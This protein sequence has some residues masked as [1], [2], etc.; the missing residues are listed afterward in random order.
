[1]SDTKLIAV[2][3]A[4]GTQGGGLVR[5]ILDDPDGGFTARAVTRQPGSEKARGLAELGVEVVPGDA[6]RAGGL[7]VAFDGAYGAYCVTNF[8]EHAS[9]ERELAQATEMARATR[10]AGVTHVVWS[11]LEDTRRTVPL[12]DDRLPTLN[13]RYKVPHFDGKGEADAIFAAEAGP[14]S[15]LL[16]AYYWDNLLR[17]GLSERDD[18]ALELALP[19]GGARLPGIAGRDVGRCAFGIFRRGAAAIGRRFG[20]A[21]EILSG[22]EMAA[23]LSRALER[24]VV[25]RDIPFDVYR[26]LGFPGADDVTN[27][28]HYQQIRGE[29]FL[30]DRDPT[31]ARSLNPEL[32]TF[33]AW[34]EANAARLPVHPR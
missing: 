31:L 20:I 18:G 5:A 30:R 8:W 28:F 7:D 9:P 22:G 25:F 13:G 3:G 15:Y 12:D 32:L 1:M 27:M 6:D 26:S 19:L 10:R 17:A 29:A 11:T 24:R 34:L 23:A 2:V 14:T 33:D 21:G 4:T 16:G